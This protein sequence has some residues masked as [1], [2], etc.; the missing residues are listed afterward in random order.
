MDTPHTRHLTPGGTHCLFDI[1]PEFTGIPGGV[2]EC[3]TNH[4]VLCKIELTMNKTNQGKIN[5][6][7]FRQ[8]YFDHH[9]INHL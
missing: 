1:Q 7:Y 3:D 4:P 5:T 9:D 8:K 2:A 6:W